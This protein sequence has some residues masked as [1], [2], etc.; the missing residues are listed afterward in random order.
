M[1]WNKSSR[2]AEKAREMLHR[3]ENSMLSF[4]VQQRLTS[5]RGRAFWEEEII[6]REAEL[7]ERPWCVGRGGWGAGF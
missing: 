6:G 3:A 2:E 4:K 1:Q 7:H 5:H